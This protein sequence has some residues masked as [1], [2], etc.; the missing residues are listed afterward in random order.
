MNISS[1]IERCNLTDYYYEALINKIANKAYEIIITAIK[2]NTPNYQIELN[3]Q[4]GI[5]AILGDIIDNYLAQG[6]ISL[7]QAEEAKHSNT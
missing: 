2:N 3:L 6:I 7:S 1:D 4:I 5:K